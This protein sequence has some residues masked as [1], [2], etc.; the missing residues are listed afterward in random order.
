MVVNLEVSL[1]LP[2]V[3]G[4]EVE[5]TMLVTEH[6]ARQLVEQD[7]ARPLRVACMPAS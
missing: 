4:L 5:A 6:G 1:F 2:G 3:A 7:R